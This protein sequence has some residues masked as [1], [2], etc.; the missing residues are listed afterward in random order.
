MF[1]YTKKELRFIEDTSKSENLCWLEKPMA[2]LS[3]TNVTLEV[4]SVKIELTK[5]LVG[6]LF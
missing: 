3:Q 2:D 6:Y 5:T 1:F 4:E